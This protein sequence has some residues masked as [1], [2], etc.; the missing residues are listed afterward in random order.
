MS[1]TLL[2]QDCTT[3][4][5]DE[6]DHLIV[7]PPY[8]EYTH[9][10]A[11]TQENGRDSNFVSNDFGFEEISGGLM[12]YLAKYAAKASGYSL[13]F[14]DDK[15]LP[16]WYRELERQGCRVIRL[17]PWIRW[18]SPCIVKGR[19]PSMTEYVILVLGP[20]GS[21]TFS[22]PGNFSHFDA[23]CL[24]G[25]DKHKTEK[26]LDLMLQ[27]IEMFTKPDARVY[28]PCMGAGTTG[29]ACLVLGR[30]FLGVEKDRE[31]FERAE[32]RF[33]GGP[34]PNDQ[35]RLAAFRDWQAFIAGD[36]ERIKKNTD[37][38]RASRQKSRGKVI[39]DSGD[40][41]IG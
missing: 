34:S 5:F 29:L 35:T 37:K 15:S 12:T 18:S 26:P 40:E 13:I 41:I 3:L 14:S 39:A 36:K 10:N 30:K 25:S 19:P 32:G 27:I 28:D 9:S 20:G 33:Q 22:G 7:D 1:Y 38:V 17:I 16:A 2:N 8:S 21:E 23:K 6:L 11:I 4:E 24:R 31:N